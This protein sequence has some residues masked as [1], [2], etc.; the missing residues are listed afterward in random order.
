M[1]KKGVYFVKCIVE[2]ALQDKNN[3]TE[4]EFIKLLMSQCET[5]AEC[6]E[7]I[8]CLYYMEYNYLASLVSRTLEIKI[9]ELPIEHIL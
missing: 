3:L 8:K 7:A 6:R 1:C 9:D 5:V 4:D 2:F